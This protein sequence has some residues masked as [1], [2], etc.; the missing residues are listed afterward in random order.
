MK[1]TNE[2]R[3]SIETEAFEMRYSCI[4]N[5]TLSLNQTDPNPVRNLDCYFDRHNENKILCTWTEPE[6]PNGVR[7]LQEDQVTLSVRTP[8]KSI[9]IATKPREG[10]TCGVVVNALTNSW[11]ASVAVSFKFFKYGKPFI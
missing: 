10:G 3:H 1:Y 7:F 2:S 11:S 9:E 8:N 4:L 6:Y 5:H